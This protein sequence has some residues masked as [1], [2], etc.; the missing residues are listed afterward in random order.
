MRAAFPQTTHV[1]YGNA[2]AK[3]MRAVALNFSLSQRLR[4][5]WRIIFKFLFKVLTLEC[6]FVC[7]WGLL[8]RPR[9]HNWGLANGLIFDLINRSLGFLGYALRNAASAAK[10]YATNDEKTTV[11]CGVRSRERQR[12]RPCQKGVVFSSLSLSLHLYPPL[13]PNAFFFVSEYVDVLMCDSHAD[14]TF[15]RSSDLSLLISQNSINSSRGEWRDCSDVRRNR[16]PI[17]RFDLVNENLRNASYSQ[18]MR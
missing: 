16:K 5:S 14:S 11:R 2:L 3:L 6:S 4:N 1:W 18:R 12:L 17:S 9:T 15:K 13:S 8:A 7:V 10:Q